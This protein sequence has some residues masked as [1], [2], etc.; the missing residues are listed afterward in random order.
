[1]GKLELEV[2][3]KVRVSKIQKT[4]L[5]SLAGAGIALLLLSSPQAAKIIPALWKNRKELFKHK[6]KRSVTRL[7]KSGLVFF[8]ETKKGTFVRLTK[9]GERTLELMKAQQIQNARQPKRW[10]QKWRLII[11]DIKE[12]RKHIRNTLR[13]TLSAL[14][15]TRLQNSVWVYPYDCEDLIILL[16][17]RHEIGREVLYV[18]ADKIE[19]DKILRQMYSLPS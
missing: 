2:K 6:V 16:K 7:V 11:F 3:R 18:I 10:D 19:N 9:E 1:M 5:H 8:D 13:N 14:G 4:I 12:K 17:A 15:F